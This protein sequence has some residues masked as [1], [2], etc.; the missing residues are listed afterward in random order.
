MSPAA[1]LGVDI[2]TYSSKGV[3][4]TQGGAV[5]ASH[6]VPHGIAMPHP[7][8]VEQDADQVWWHDFVAISRAL[9]QSSSIAPSQIAGIGISSI[10]PCVLPVDEAGQPL[11]PGILYGIDTRARQEI[12]ELEHAVGRDVLFTRYGTTLSAQSA[13][14]KIRWLRMHEP[15]VWARTRLLLSGTGY[16]VYR[17]TGAATLDIYDAGAYAPL[18][19]TRTLGWNP[20][21]ADLIA[22]V[23][24]LPRLTWTCAIAGHVTPDAAKI[25]GLAEGTPVITGTADAAAEA[26]SAGLA[27]AGDLMLMAGSSIFFILKTDHLVASPRFWGTRFLEPDTYAVAGGMS[28]AGSLTKWFRDQF[29]QSEMQAEQ[30]GGPDAYA[31]LAQLAQSSRPGAHGLIALPYFAGERTP[32][33]DP[34]A[35]GLI[36]G[37]TLNHSRGDVYRALLEAVGYGIRHNVDAM[38]DEGLQPARILAVGG[39]THN[40]AWMQMISDIAGIEL[41]IPSQQIGAAYGDAF[42]A[43]VGVGA[44]AGTGEAAA[45][46]KT[47]TIVRPDDGAQAAY[48]P[49][50]RVYRELY[51]QTATSMHA[52]AALARSTAPD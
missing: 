21:M 38:R 27:H 15:E 42:L 44:F 17:L 43:G 1:F 30:E 8:W 9:I 28:T 45:W 19:D 50:Y 33:H 4:V 10:S 11:R 16:L 26:I 51:V 14:P 24:L 31:A 2:G 5:L 40:L 3:L 35:R 18:F 12:A 41:H 46:V 34:D 36:V 29:A 37:L 47:G 7:G 52:L 6:I 23:D 22:P 20:D 49:Y 13:G 25:T 32:L 39:G 48:A